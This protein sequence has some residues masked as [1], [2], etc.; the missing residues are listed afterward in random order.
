MRRSLSRLSG[1]IRV[2]S[3]GFTLIELLVVI[4]II[5]ILI[6]LL[7]PAVQKVREAAARMKCQNNL[8]QFG[9]ALHGYH[10][11]NDRFPPG[12]VGGFYTPTWNGGWEPDRGSWLVYTLPYIEQ[13][14]LYKMLTAAGITNWTSTPTP[15]GGTWTNGTG[16]GWFGDNNGPAP[17]KQYVRPYPL[18]RCPSDDY[19]RD[20]DAV[21][22]YA[23][24]MGAQCLPTDCGAE[25]FACATLLPNWGISQ[26]NAGHGN[27]ANSSQLSGMFNRVGAKIGISSIKDGTSNT[28]MVG[29]I[30]PFLHDHAWD[31]NTIPWA[32]LNGGAAHV[33]TIVPINYGMNLK[34]PGADPFEHIWTCSD[35][36]TMYSGRNWNVSWGFKSNHS[37]GANFVFGDGSVRFLSQSIDARTYGLLGARSDG[38]AVTIP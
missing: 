10:D 38:L 4:A 31:S 33:S 5:A 28:I 7:L 8:K 25:V 3:R 23:G 16:P 22:N 32:R 9:I 21:C 36:V 1:A 26:L 20:A 17:G 30:L 2:L 27:D 14:G 11:V 19:H 12:G 6:R 34:R 18:F 29:E 35:G 24:S 37:G 15:A 13:D